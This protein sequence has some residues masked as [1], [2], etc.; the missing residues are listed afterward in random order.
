MNKRNNM[1]SIDD[2]KPITLED[3]PLFDEHYKKYPPNHSDNV[4]TTLISWLEYGNYNYVFIDEN[5]IIYSNINNQIRFRPPSGP[6][7]KELFDQVLKLAKQ[8]NSDYPLGVI[9]L[10]TKNWMA[11]N[12]P[13]MDFIEHRGYFD[14]VYLA[15]DLAELQ[16]SAYSKIRNRLNKFKKNYKHTVEKI[17]EENIGELKEF[18][19]RWCLW[20][21]CES[22]PILE[23]EKKA[24]LYSTNHFFE[25]GLNGILIRMNDKIESMA[26][27]EKMNPDTGIVHYEKG[28]PDF[29]GIYKAINQETAKILQKDNKFIDREPDMDIPGLRKA[30]MSYKPHHMIEVYH[31]NNQRILI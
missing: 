29:D 15:S 27:F 1:L 16:G 13:K 4:F 21:D 12:Y 31:V 11:K 6:R 19:K 9:D 5:L 8:Q 10:E 20:K 17:S 28:S 22:D 7:K 24:I 14:Y 26:V 3:K 2:L 30:K 25:L 18:L 23:N